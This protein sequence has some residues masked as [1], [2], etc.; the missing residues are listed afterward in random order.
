MKN[1][2]IFRNKKVY[3]RNDTII[4]KVDYIKKHNKK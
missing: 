1:K 2:D 3:E 4:I